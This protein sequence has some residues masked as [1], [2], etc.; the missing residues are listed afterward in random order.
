MAQAY[1]LVNAYGC[2]SCLAFLDTYR[3]LRNRIS[4]CAR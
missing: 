1:E 3:M 4:I 2:G